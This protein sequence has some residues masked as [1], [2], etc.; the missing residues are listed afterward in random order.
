MELLCPKTEEMR[1]R[2]NIC[3]FNIGIAVSKQRNEDNFDPNKSFRKTFPN[4]KNLCTVV[5]CINLKGFFIKGKKKH[6]DMP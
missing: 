2:N 3:L 6:F 5:S 4:T 1:N